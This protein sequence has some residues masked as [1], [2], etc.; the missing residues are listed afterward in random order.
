[1]GECAFIKLPK[2]DRPPNKRLSVG[3]KIKT[4]SVVVPKD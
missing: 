1:M 4:K 2:A 3:K